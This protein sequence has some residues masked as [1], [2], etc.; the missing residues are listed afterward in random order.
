MPRS[1]SFKLRPTANVFQAP[2][3]MEMS[4]LAPETLPYSTGFPPSADADSPADGPQ[5]A[6]P[7]AVESVLAS[8]AFNL[9]R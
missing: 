9:D 8:S 1:I 4:N 6:V 3:S 2:T 5:S 7:L